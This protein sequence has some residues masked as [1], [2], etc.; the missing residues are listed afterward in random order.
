MNPDD[1]YFRE[2]LAQNAVW[3]EE[4]RLN[5]NSAR[6]A[7]NLLERISNRTY[8]NNLTVN[9]N[10]NSTISNTNTNSII[11]ANTRNNNSVLSNTNRSTIY[12]NIE[13]VNPT[14]YNSNGGRRRQSKKT[15]KSTRRRGRKSR[16]MM[17]RK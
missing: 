7:R 16:R 8:L 12:N 10:N 15:R 13:E 17:Y 14:N 3:R 11:T 5:Q 4:H 9:S 6:R 2:I 1:E